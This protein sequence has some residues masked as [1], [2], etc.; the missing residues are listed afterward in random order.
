MRYGQSAIWL[1]AFLGGLG[2]DDF[3]A[4]ARTRCCR[5]AQVS[6]ICLAH[7]LRSARPACPFAGFTFLTASPLPSLTN[8]SGAGFSHLLAIA[9]DD[10]VLGLGP[11]S[12]WDD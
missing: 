11:D 4:I 9:Y 2:T 3:R 8:D 1:E 7:A 6:G 12:P 5:H 10:Y